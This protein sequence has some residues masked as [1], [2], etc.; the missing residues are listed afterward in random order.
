MNLS[1]AY[2]DSRF[3][4]TWT[5]FDFFDFRDNKSSIRRQK[6]RVSDLHFLRMI[7]SSREIQIALISFLSYMWVLA[8]ESSL[9]WV[10]FAWPYLIS[11]EANG[12]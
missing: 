5:W 9:N 4:S 2:V 11:E 1:V 7:I 6:R 10:V 12:R 3:V 8:D